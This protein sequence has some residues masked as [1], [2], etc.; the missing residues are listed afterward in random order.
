[1]R[2]TPPNAVAPGRTRRRRRGIAKRTLVQRSGL[3]VFSV[4]PLRIYRVVSI[5]LA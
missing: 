4:K 2:V 5:S 3:H 1:M